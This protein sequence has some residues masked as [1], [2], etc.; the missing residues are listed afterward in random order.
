MPDLEFNTP[1]IGRFLVAGWMLERLLHP[2]IVS[3]QEPIQRFF[4]EADTFGCLLKVVGSDTV[5][6]DERKHI[7]VHDNLSELLHEVRGECGV[8]VLGLME[9][10]AVWVEPHHVDKGVN[11]IV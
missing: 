6:V 3:R 9:V 7:S 1:Q 10:S 4:G 8:P 5:V 2:S 11:V